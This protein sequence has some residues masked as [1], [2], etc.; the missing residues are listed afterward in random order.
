MLTDGGVWDECV[1]HHILNGRGQ[2]EKPK[3][4]PKFTVSHAVLPRDA[5]EDRDDCFVQIMNL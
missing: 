2:E 1:D 5:P 4:P 3:K